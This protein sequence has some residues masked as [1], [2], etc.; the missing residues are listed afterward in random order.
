MFKNVVK[1]EHHNMIKTYG[2]IL[3]LAGALFYLLFGTY[4]TA[5]KRLKM[6]RGIGW[7]V[8]HGAG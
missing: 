6:G 3:Y 5:L 7:E 2:R 8:L 4:H 1:R